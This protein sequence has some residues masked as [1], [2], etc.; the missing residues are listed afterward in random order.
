MTDTNLVETLQWLMQCDQDQ[1]KNFGL[2]DVICK[3]CFGKLEKPGKAFDETDALQYS[4]N[5]YGIEDLQEN[6]YKPVLLFQDVIKH[7]KGDFERVVGVRS[8]G[9]TDENTIYHL[10]ILLI[11]IT[12][13][14]KTIKIYEVLLK[15]TS[16]DKK[17]RNKNLLI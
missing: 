12:L 14:Y 17:K 9:L 3:S 1:E 10:T 8:C 4:G 11:G 6:C 15:I 13:F 7:S 5:I 2:F 16:N